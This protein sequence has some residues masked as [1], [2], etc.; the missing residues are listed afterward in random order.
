M[1]S[2]SNPFYKKSI[3]RKRFF[4]LATFEEKRPKGQ[5]STK[6]AKEICYNKINI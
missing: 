5:V 3:T 4:I 6:F 1:S 2:V